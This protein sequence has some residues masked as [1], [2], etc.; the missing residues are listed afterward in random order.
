VSRTPSVPEWIDLDRLA[1]LDP[2]DNSWRRW[3]ACRE[4]DHEVF[5]PRSDRRGKNYDYRS[6]RALCARCPSRLACL[7]AWLPTIQPS[8]DAQSGCYVGG[9]TPAERTAVRKALRARR[10]A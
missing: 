4:K 5:F 10:A 1:A 8:P 7:A 9:C 3:K 2:D 6:A